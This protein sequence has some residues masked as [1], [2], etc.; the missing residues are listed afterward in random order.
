MPLGKKTK[1]SFLTGANG[2]LGE[3][4]I[5]YFKHSKYEISRLTRDQLNLILEA[6]KEDT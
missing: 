2:Y 4:F 6:Y 5:N 1:N 3:Y